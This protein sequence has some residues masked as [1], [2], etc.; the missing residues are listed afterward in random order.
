MAFAVWGKNETHQKATSNFNFSY[1][2]N[3][4]NLQRC[5]E[6]TKKGT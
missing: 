2:F 6:L 1:I 4:L 3:R 5:L